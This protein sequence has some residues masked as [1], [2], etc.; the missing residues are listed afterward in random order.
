MPR[1]LAALAACARR[2]QRALARAALAAAA[3]AAPTPLWAISI[4]FDYSYDAGAFFGT[5]ASPTPARATLEL[6]A[7]TF[8][9]FTDLLAPI[10]PAG[11]NHWT[12]QFRNPGTGAVASIP[13][14]V[15]PQDT[16]LIFA[17]G[18]NLAGTRLGEAGPGSYSFPPGSSPGAAFADAVINRGQGPSAA[19][20]AP[21]GGFI[22]F[23]TIAAGGAPRRWHFDP[24]SAPAADAY[25]F[26]TVAVHELAHLL[27]FGT[28]T[29][30]ASDR[31][32]GQFIGSAA[33]DLYGGA[34][35]LHTDGQHW[36]AAVASPPYAS[37]VKPSLGPSLTAGDRKLFT[38]LDYAGMA[39]VGWSITPQQ[40]QLPGD[41]DGDAD[42]DGADFLTWQR[43]LG[44]LG[45]S[46]GDVNG[47]LVVDGY[48]GWLLQANV[49]A[50]GAPA[51][52]AATAAVPEPAAGVLLALS[53][54]ATRTAARTRR[55]APVSF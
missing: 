53:A 22:E 5:A 31:S 24:R 9:S 4:E 34:V 19:D 45:G 18:R 10:Q 6:A 42:V 48:D 15:V 52:A 7:R 43:N 41:I 33:V 27:G 20:F 1:Q 14:L 37:P 54:L 17:G 55:K 35:P 40:L 47:D 51:S 30:F 3:V 2:A 38:P 36:S 50:L 44:G 21:W 46:P 26:Y 8:S 49:G 12:A 25:D 28:S 32:S 39:D 16:V 23:D 29:A 13:D 11:T